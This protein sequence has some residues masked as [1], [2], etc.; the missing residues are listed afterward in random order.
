M[1]C[2]SVVGVCCEGAEAMTTLL[3]L[4]YA[5]VVR[6]AMTTLDAKRLACVSSQ[7]KF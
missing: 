4:W 3:L 2:D 1:V 5:C 7:E 6:W